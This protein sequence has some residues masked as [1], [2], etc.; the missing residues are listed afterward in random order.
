MLSMN[1][2]HKMRGFSL[3]ELVIVIV[4]IGVIAAIAVPRISRGGRGA[5]DSAVRANLAV[6]RNAIDMYAVEHN[7]TFPAQDNSATTFVDQLTNKT[8]IDGNVGSAAGTHVYG[9]YM[10]KGLPPLSVGPNKGASGISIATSGPTVDE[11]A[12]DIGWVYNSATG[13][14]IAN[15]DDED[16]TQT[17][18]DSY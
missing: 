15:T 16:E 2:S 14:I 5:A 7:N 8:D 3:V 1:T 9:P 4:I 18:Y 13:E 17:S 11:S 6:L 10:R 12:T